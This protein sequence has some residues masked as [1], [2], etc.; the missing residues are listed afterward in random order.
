M[1]RLF[2]VLVFVAV[3]F[4]F[5]CAGAPVSAPSTS[6]DAPAVECADTME[7]LPPPLFAAVELRIIHTNDL[8][9]RALENRTELGYAR[10]A[11]L[12]KQLKAE[13]PNTLVI[14]AGDTFHGLPF[15]NLER[16]SSIAKLLNAVGYDYMTVGNHDFNYGQARLLELEKEINFPI[17]R[18]SVV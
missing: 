6:A 17:D 7:P 10:I 16:G 15:A 9:A 2:G 11:T 18:K 5:G 14:D 12:V 3:L 1:K 4:A 13:N 8:H